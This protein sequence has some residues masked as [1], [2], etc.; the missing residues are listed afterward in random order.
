[1]HIPAYSPVLCGVK[2]FDQRAVEVETKKVMAIELAPII[3]GVVEVDE[4]MDMA[5]VAVAVISI[6]VDI[7]ILGPVRWF[8]I[9]PRIESTGRVRRVNRER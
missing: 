1:M 5:A 7:S 3:M 2:D 4:G 8:P 6:V 9:S